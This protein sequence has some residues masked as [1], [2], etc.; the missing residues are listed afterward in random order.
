MTKNG[1][2]KILLK[3]KSRKKAVVHDWDFILGTKIHSMGCYISKY[4]F[5]SI[6][7]KSKIE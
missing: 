2:R 1:G 7:I 4:R 6:L 5:R 3:I